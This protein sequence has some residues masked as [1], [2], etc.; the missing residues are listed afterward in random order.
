MEKRIVFT[1]KNELK[2][3]EFSLAAQGDNQVTVRNICSLI[4]T[5]TELIVLNRMFDPGTHW[6]NWIKY[7]FYPGYAAMGEIVSAG[8][9]VSC[10][11]P[12]DQVVHRGGHASAAIVDDSQCFPVPDGVKPETACWF[13]LA[14]IA[15]MSVP[16]A[17][18][19][20]GG[21]VA[22]IGAGPVGQMATRWA[23][24]AGAE[25]VILID[26]VPMRLEMAGR[27]GAARTV[28]ATA[29]NA[30]DE[31]RQINGGDLPDVVIDST[32]HAAVFSDA[33]KIV[34]SHGRLVLLGD[35][36]SPGLQHLSPDVI[37]RGLTITGVH[38]MHENDNWNSKKII[39]LFF[40]FCQ[41]GRFN[42]D[43]LITHRF[44]PDE[45]VQAYETASK[46]R[47]ETMG[48]LFDWSK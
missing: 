7:P 14:K 4:S 15:A 42:V 21:S 23:L 48:M 40:K 24:A 29:G 47:S 45:C 28:C 34:N 30:A 2:L 26:T 36:G 18:Y 9:N 27:G 12:G 37:M 33:L 11:K 46:H 44:T 38:D 13:A 19:G 20:I 31:I 17:H 41:S 22:V 1:G 5:G 16:A 43:G 25:P 3:E 8:K 35:T 39:S 6:D 32:G 10:L